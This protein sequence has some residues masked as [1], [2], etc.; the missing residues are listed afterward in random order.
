MLARRARQWSTHHRLPCLTGVADGSGPSVAQAIQ[1][2]R[3]QAAGDIAV[4]SFFH[5][6][7]ELLHA[8]ADG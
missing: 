3:A 4:G 1:G 6:H 7:R 5:R 2:L 8:Q